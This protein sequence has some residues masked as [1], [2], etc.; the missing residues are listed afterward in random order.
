[1]ATKK[2]KTSGRRSKSGGYYYT[3]RRVDS[4][5]NLSPRKGGKTPGFFSRATDEG[6]RSYGY[7]KRAA[8]DRAVRAARDAYLTPI[9]TAIKKQRTEL[10]QQEKKA[11]GIPTRLRFGQG[12]IRRSRGIQGLQQRRRQSRAYQQQ[13]VSL[14]RKALDTIKQSRQALKKQ[15]A[16]ARAVAASIR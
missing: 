16:R 6:I 8:Y 3:V 12:Q 4:S 13:A 9:L 2:V 11:M 15:E 1:M 7:S 14:Q 5:G 10:T